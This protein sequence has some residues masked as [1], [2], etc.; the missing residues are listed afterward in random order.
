LGFVV[1]RRR[2]ASLVRFRPWVSRTLVA[3]LWAF[4][5]CFEHEDQIHPFLWLP[6]ATAV[7]FAQG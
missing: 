2:R 3:A 7:V 4:H 5:C 6:R 1:V